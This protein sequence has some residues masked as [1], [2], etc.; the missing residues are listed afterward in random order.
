VLKPAAIR[1]GVAG[2]AA[3]VHRDPLGSRLDA[4]RLEPQLGHARAATYRH[5]E[6][7]RAKA[8]PVGEA[9]RAEASLD[10]HLAGLRRAAHLDAVGPQGLGHELA[11]GR[12]L[13]RQ[14][15]LPSLQDRH[16]RAESPQ[17]LPSSIPTAPPPRTITL[18][19][20]S[21]RVVAWR[22]VQ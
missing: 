18:S 21:A 8:P 11:D 2:P 15:A 10:A 6:L 3:L 19:G 22:F 12:L 4:R 13:P 7:A 17:E 5:Q 9:H 16:R 1:A 20:G 14:E